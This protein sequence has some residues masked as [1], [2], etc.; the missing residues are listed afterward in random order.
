MKHDQ[1]SYDQKLDL[2]LATSA[3]V[4]AAKG[5]HNAT[6]RDI[7]KAS[8]VSLSGLYYYF[9]SKD[10]LLYLIQE[11]VLATLL[12]RIECAVEGI[13]DPQD[14][15]EALMRAHL[16]YFLHNMAEMKV[17]SHEADSLSGK[18]RSGIN[19]TKRQITDI[20]AG[21]LH[22][23][24]PGSTIDPRVA[25]FGLFG[26]MN[27]IYNWYRPG[28]DASPETLISDMAS[29]F[30]NGYLNEQEAVLSSPPTLMVQ[31]A[32]HQRRFG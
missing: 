4:F 21:I 8:G 32:T 11:N 10:E 19:A 6:I 25:T 7:S 2:I 17:L 14:R 3:E 15:L 27:W 1:T 31:A 30:L 24:R 26:M 12:A 16:R 29:L 5:F 13:L 23:L 20:A 28:R 9:E 22:E 18:F